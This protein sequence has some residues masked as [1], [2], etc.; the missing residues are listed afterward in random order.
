MALQIT[1]GKKAGAVRGIISGTEGI[2]KST[3]AAQI[4]NAL[5]ID[6]EDGTGQID[7][8]RA[9]ALD[10]RAIEHATKELVADSQGFSAIVYDSVD[11]LER[12]L[13]DFMLKQSG[14]KSIEDFGYGKGYTMLQ[15]HVSRFLGLADQLVAKGIHVVFVA[16]TKTVR[17]SPP[18][19]TDGYDRYE[20][21]L[22]KQV[23]PL[24]REWSD[25]YLFCNYKI[26]IVEGSDG[27]LKAQGGKER[28]MYASRCAAWDA[29]NRYGLP[30]EMPMD[31]SE[32]AH[33]FSGAAPR[34]SVAAQAESSAD[35]A[36]VSDPAPE[37]AQEFTPATAE[38]VG[39]L[40]TYAKNSVGA[41]FVAEA[42][43]AAN[44]VGVDELSASDAEALID[45]IQT[46]MNA[47]A[48]KPAAPT[49]AN[50]PSSKIPKHIAAWLDA[51]AEKVNDWILS[52]R[53]WS[54]LKN[55]QTWRD[56][57]ADCLNTIVDKP[58]KFARAVGIAPLGGKAA[59]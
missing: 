10:W 26:Q 6:T 20:M 8:A 51:N 55:G 52:K 35:A 18:D 7:C 53:D 57:S 29:K 2:G 28:V 38:Q 1:K 42:L 11:W 48:E 17:V 16:H 12:S 23:A 59:A 13:I 9:L 44:A 49:P 40:E 22:T 19:Q 47:A 45:A 56:L 34:A 25:L 5:I 3:L 36:Q 33:V 43:D 14:K 41:P 39:Q 30:D 27:R 50:A 37:P 31:Y 24:I 54:K 15:E 32:I 21:K 4:P 46:A 58:D